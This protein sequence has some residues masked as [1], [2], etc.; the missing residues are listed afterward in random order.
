M[1]SRRQLQCEA[2]S[3]A[4]PAKAANDTKKRGGKE[5]RRSSK[6]KADPEPA[7]TAVAAS[8]SA[9]TSV[10]GGSGIKLENVSGI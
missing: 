4:A 8:S 9:T 3:K 7:D 1:Q 2:V 10:G 6:A 5:D